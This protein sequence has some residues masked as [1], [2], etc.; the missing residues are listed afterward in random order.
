MTCVEHILADGLGMYFLWDSSLESIS[1]NTGEISNFV[2][3]GN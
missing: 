3:A 2:E 1:I